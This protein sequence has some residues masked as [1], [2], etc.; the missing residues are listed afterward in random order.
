MRVIEAIESQLNVAVLGVFGGCPPASGLFTRLAIHSVLHSLNYCERH[1]K[2]LSARK[3]HTVFAEK[4]DVME[5]ACSSV[6]ERPRRSSRGPAPEHS[7]EQI[8]AAAIELADAEGLAA[9]TMRAIAKE[10]HTGP[11]SLYRYVRTRDE[12]IELMVDRVYGEFDYSRLASQSWE[13]DL[14]ELAHQ[15]REIYLR[16]SWLL[17]IVT[18]SGPNGPNVADYL[19]NALAALDG[20]D[21]STK[22]EAVGVLNALVVMLTRNEITAKESDTAKYRAYSIL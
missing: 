17:E 13:T 21:A 4:G 1:S 10:L 11:A 19:E 20:V 7:L 5:P 9:V 22:L 18:E 16:H 12:L 6:W 8:A 3:L 2:Y 14:L 15:S